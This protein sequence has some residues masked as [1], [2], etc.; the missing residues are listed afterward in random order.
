VSTSA[1]IRL[2]SFLFTD[3]AFASVRDHM[4]PGGLFVLYNYYRQPWLIEKMA[5][6]LEQTFGGHVLVRS[7]NQGIANAASLAAGPAVAELH[8]SAPPGDVIDVIDTTNAP[9]P[10]TDDWPFLYLREPS[11]PGHYLLALGLVLAWAI[12]LVWRGAVR[13]GTQL[14]RFS[15]HFFVL[16]IAF[17]LLETRSIVTFSLLFGSTWL[18]NSLVFFAVLA[19]VL[20]AIAVAHRLSR[21]YVPLL[22]VLLFGSIVVAWALPPASLLI[23]PPWLRYGVAAVLA[24]APIF[25]ANLVFSASFRD[26]RAADMAFASNLLGAMVGGAIEYLALVTGYQALLIVVA[27][28]YAVAWLFGR[29][30]RRLGDRDLDWDAA[31]R[32]YAAE[33]QAAL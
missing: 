29:R 1:N 4:A 16:G 18:V 10:A 33:V 21:M 27:G 31:A 28:L 23:D 12:A 26:T 3:E 5:A 20:V 9:A 22:Y 8:G 2:E 14:R 15:P 11:I 13:S 25:F 19:S 17:L 32:N 30:L 6:M 24:F 7:Y